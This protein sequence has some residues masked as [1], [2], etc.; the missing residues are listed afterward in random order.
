MND[1]QF[2][3]RVYGLLINADRE[4]LLS[5]E[6]RF[7]KRFTKFPGGGLEQGEGTISCLKRECLEEMNQ[8]I[9]NI[10]HF[11]TTDFYQ[12]SYFHTA[13][14]I[15][16]VYYTFQLTGNQCFS[17]VNRA[18][19]HATSAS[20]DFEVFRWKKVDDLEVADLTFP[21]DQHVVNLIKKAF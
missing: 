3:I 8:P 16:S 7:G 20:D 2:T 17:T 9:E 15:L 19:E 4:V 13:K 11:Y 6:Q 21:I 18:F 10:E 14:Q 1:P 12:P 5:D